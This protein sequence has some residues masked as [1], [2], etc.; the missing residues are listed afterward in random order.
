MPL[1]VPDQPGHGMDMKS[2]EVI[3]GN[4]LLVMNQGNRS[5]TPVSDQNSNP[6]SS[7]GCPLAV[8][9][10]TACSVN[11][12]SHAYSGGCPL[13]ASVL[14]GGP[15]GIEQTSSLR[16][17]YPLASVHRVHSLQTAPLTLSSPAKRLQGND[18]GECILPEMCSMH[19]YT[20]TVGY[21]DIYRLIMLWVIG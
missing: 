16:G 2:P 17:G 5:V 18:E 8:E 6:L 9:E 14:G 13:I 11:I 21:T 3:H 15:S 10:R 12:P 7:G 4:S 1:F 19:A 20:Y